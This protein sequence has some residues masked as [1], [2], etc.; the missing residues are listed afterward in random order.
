MR[1]PVVVSFDINFVLPA[2]IAL[3]SLLRNAKSNT[4]Y[5]INIITSD[6]SVKDVFSVEKL[7]E[8]FNNFSIDFLFVQDTFK[9]AYEVRGI[10]YAAYWRLLIPEL[11]REKEK[12]LYMDVDI[13]VQ[14][15]LSDLYNID[16]EDKIIAGFYDY[17]MNRTESG[18]NYL[19]SVL[20]IKTNSYIQSGFLVLDLVSMRKY[21]VVNTFKLLAKNKYVLQDQDIINIACCNK[22]KILPPNRNIVCQSF[23]MLELYRDDFIIYDKKDMFNNSIIHYNGI[24]PWNGIAYNDEIWWK[25]FIESPFFSYEF[26]KKHTLN[27]IKKNGGWL[28]NV[29]NFINK[30]CR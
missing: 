22:I 4:F 30:I 21:D 20:K 28:Y 24:K 13:I 23:E 16:L 15:D 26:Y 1:I 3:Y 27:K 8:K 11:L 14:S 19:S 7:K 12:V 18:Q 5:E 17:G 9:D 25:Y 6:V 29:K 10:S 2:E